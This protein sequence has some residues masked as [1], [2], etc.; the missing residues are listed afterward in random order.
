MILPIITNPHPTLR[1]KAK[2]VDVKEIKTKEFQQFISNM[3]ETMKAKDGVG[4]AAPQVN[5]SSRVICVADK[6]DFPFVLI[7]PKILWSSFRKEQ[8]EEGC[9]SLPGTFVKVKRSKSIKVEMLDIS[10]NKIQI[11]TEGV[12]ARAIQHEIDHLDGILIIDNG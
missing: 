5:V 4:L 12:E 3:L 8:A 10:G 2:E 1:Q 11:K 7:N 6:N 9:L